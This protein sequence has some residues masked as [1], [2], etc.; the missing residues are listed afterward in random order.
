MRITYKYPETTL[1]S[2][3]N[4]S[5]FKKAFGE[6]ENEFYEILEMPETFILYRFF[7]EWLGNEKNYH[8]STNAWSQCWQETFAKL[9]KEE[10]DELKKIIHENRFSSIS[11]KYENSK[12]SKLLKFYTNYRDDINNPKS[13]IY[14]LKQEYDKNPTRKLRKRM[15]DC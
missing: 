13:E 6:N 14:N 1:H 7:F 3:K 15:C 10:T 4:E 9:N 11:K 8:I 5:F 12:F 2:N